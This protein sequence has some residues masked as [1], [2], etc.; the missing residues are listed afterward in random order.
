VVFV[1]WVYE[2]D[3]TMRVEGK[4]LEYEER[5]SEREFPWLEEEGCKLSGKVVME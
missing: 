5:R 1:E 2:I 3:L 4:I